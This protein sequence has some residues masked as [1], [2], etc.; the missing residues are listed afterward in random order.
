[1]TIYFLVSWLVSD[2]CGLSAA[3]VFVCFFNISSN[4]FSRTMAIGCG[5]TALLEFGIGAYLLGTL[6]GKRLPAGLMTFVYVVPVLLFNVLAISQSAQMHGRPIEL[7]QYGCQLIGPFVSYYC[8]EWGQSSGYSRPNTMLN[9]PWQHWIWILPTSLW[10]VVTIPLFL[11]LL[12]WHFDSVIPGIIICTILAGIVGAIKKSQS[13]LS[14]N[15]GSVGKRILTVAGTWVLLTAL[16]VVLLAFM[17]GRE[18]KSLDS[19]NGKATSN[20][21]P[22]GQSA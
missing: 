1:L 12:M 7:V 5:G 18:M 4:E 9:I 11:L 17:L 15:D 21:A 2:I 3:T 8:V 6:V 22:A 19:A 10:Q 20:T 16:Q 14:Q 13:A